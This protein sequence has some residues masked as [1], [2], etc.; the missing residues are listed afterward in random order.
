MSEFTEESE[1]HSESD[2]DTEEYMLI[3]F[4]PKEIDKICYILNYLI[5]TD[6]THETFTYDDIETI[7]SANKYT[8]LFF[9]YAL[10]ISEDINT[11]HG[12]IVGGG[13]INAT[14][15][16]ILLLLTFN[17]LMVDA[18][19]LNKKTALHFKSIH[20]GMSQRI[21]PQT[22]LRLSETVIEL[23]TRLH[24]YTPPLLTDFTKI[25][26]MARDT[27]KISKIFVEQKKQINKVC[28]YIIKNILLRKIKSGIKKK[29]IHFVY[30][31]FIKEIVPKI[32]PPEL[33]LAS[34]QF[35]D[36]ILW[37]IQNKIPETF[38]WSKNIK[39]EIKEFYKTQMLQPMNEAQV[40]YGSPFWGGKKSIK[41]KKRSF[42]RS[43]KNIK[44]RKKN[45]KI[46]MKK[47]MMNGM[48]TP[49]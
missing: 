26:T 27:A 13:I 35:A 40:A 20:H 2:S 32:L 6:N 21:T 9:Y 44:H 38:K 24:K 39:T 12:E 47:T 48:M 8:N 10:H 43:K 1:S 34:I 25:T 5:L 41:R 16:F 46:T 29:I 30:I 17:T 15:F 42:I 31:C 49:K 4:T 3:E 45:T 33:Q 28:S 22:T 11:H 14:I 23:S 7:S 37:C 19:L 36:I 18:G